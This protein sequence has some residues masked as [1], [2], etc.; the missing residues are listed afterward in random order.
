MNNAQAI[1][2]KDLSQIGL[3]AVAGAAMCVVMFVLPFTCPSL[4]EQKPSPDI[5]KVF[6]AQAFD[7]QF[8]QAVTGKKHFM[9]DAITGEHVYQPVFVREDLTKILADPSCHLTMG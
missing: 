9:C 7:V 8:R 1:S 6:R 2:D 4:F 3:A 5:E